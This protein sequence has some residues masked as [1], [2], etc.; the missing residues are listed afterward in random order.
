MFVRVTRFR[1]APDQLDRLEIVI[2][3]RTQPP[4]ANTFVRVSD[5]EP[6]ASRGSPAQRLVDAF[7]ARCAIK[8]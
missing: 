1:S 6:S 8:R 5:L 4:H 7:E 3:E 2:M